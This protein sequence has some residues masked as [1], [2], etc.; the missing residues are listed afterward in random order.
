MLERVETLQVNYTPLKRWNR[1][2]GELD[3]T[4]LC[5]LGMLILAM[6]YVSVVVINPTV[7]Q[8][9]SA[10]DA[11]CS[12]YLDF[13]FTTDVAYNANWAKIPESN[14]TDGSR[15]WQR[16]EEEIESLRFNEKLLDRVLA[17]PSASYQCPAQAC[18]VSNADG[19]L[20]ITNIPD[21]CWVVESQWRS[22]NEGML[23]LRN[24]G[25]MGVSDFSE[26]FH[27]DCAEFENGMDEYPE[28]SPTPEPTLEPTPPPTP[29]PYPSPARTPTYT[30]EPPPPLPPRSAGYS[31]VRVYTSFTD[32]VFYAVPDA[33]PCSSACTD[34]YKP[35]CRNGTCVTP[36]C[37]DAL[38]YCDFT[39]LAGQAARMFC[40]STCG[41]DQ[42]GPPLM[43]KL[44]SS[45]CPTSCKTSANYKS[46]NSIVPCN[47]TAPTNSNTDPSTNAGYWQRMRLRDLQEYVTLW[48]ALAIDSATMQERAKRNSEDLMRLGC[49][50]YV[51]KMS[52]EIDAG[53]P[54]QAFSIERICG[55]LSP[56]TGTERG[57][58]NAPITGLQYLCPVSCKC[59]K[60]NTWGCPT[61]YTGAPAGD[62]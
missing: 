36:T 43:S 61:Q 14:S 54:R 33:Q 11:L 39:N 1:C 49:A 55:S 19:N 22:T 46:A 44:V 12:G 13:V 21:C 52:S 41:C 51:N 8:L 23:S 4:I 40:P 3:W 15:P 37:N 10:S 17:W 7:K 5:K 42:P 58:F 24:L 59:S 60:S 26:S 35:W 27:P 62:I 25:S 31:K 34:P 28:P 20:S 53:G 48:P 47:D 38:P 16:P 57:P 29:S 45:G 56:I 6:P 2:F 32:A 9:W 30:P 18:N 50:A